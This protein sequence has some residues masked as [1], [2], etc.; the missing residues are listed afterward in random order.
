MENRANTPLLLSCTI[1]VP[2][3]CSLHSHKKPNALRLNVNPYN[4]SRWKRTRGM[5]P[6]AKIANDAAC[7]EAPLVVE[8]CMYGSSYMHRPFIVADGCPVGGE[9]RVRLGVWGLGGGDAAVL[10]QG[11][12]GAGVRRLPRST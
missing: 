8:E 6:K 2:P 12:L 5:R 1:A 3:P 7:H 9:Y 4:A 10:P 11:H